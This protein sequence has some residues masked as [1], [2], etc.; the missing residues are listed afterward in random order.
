RGGRA[1]GGE[2]EAVGQLPVPGARRSGA[3]GSAVDGAI[4]IV[5][6]SPGQELGGQEG[7]QEEQL[8]S[9]QQAVALPA[10]VVLDHPAPAE[11]PQGQDVAGQEDNLVAVTGGLVAVQQPVAPGVFGD[12][13]LQAGV[14]G[15]LSA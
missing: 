3:L 8:S 9:G 12:M 2:G 5:E 13:S 6:E 7:R 14:F 4:G 1:P 11:D 15:A 10:P